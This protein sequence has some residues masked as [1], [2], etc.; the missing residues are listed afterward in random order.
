MRREARER[1]SVPEFNFLHCSPLI[2]YD[3]V[4]ALR[5]ALEEGPERQR[6]GGHSGRPTTEQSPRGMP[7]SGR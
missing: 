6:K 7:G 2:M 4:P 1:A 5:E 3:V